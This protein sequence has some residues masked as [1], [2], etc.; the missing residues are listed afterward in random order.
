MVKS[1]PFPPYDWHSLSQRMA[2]AI[3]QRETEQEAAGMSA[4]VQPRP[5]NG[6]RLTPER[7]LQ[8]L[9]GDTL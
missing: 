3:R 8:M 9:P 6:L 2:Q 1:G 7:F 4:H 5:L